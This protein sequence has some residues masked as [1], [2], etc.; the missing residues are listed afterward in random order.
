M[1]LSEINK[2]KNIRRPYNHVA[3]IDIANAS[4]TDRAEI[5][6]GVQDIFIYAFIV[7]AYSEDGYRLDKITAGCDLFKMSVYDD[8]GNHLQTNPVVYSS[9]NK[10]NTIPS[11]RGYYFTARS[12]VTIEME[13]IGF[14]GAAAITYPAKFKV[15]LFGYRLDNYDLI[16]QAGEAYSRIIRPYTFTREF[17]LATNTSTDSDTID[18]GSEDLFVH[19]IQTFGLDSSGRVLEEINTFQDII[20][21]KM[22]HGAE[23]F[24][25]NWID[26]LA[27]NEAMKSLHW[28][29]WILE[30]NR[31]L[32][33][34]TKAEDFPGTAV[35]NFPKKWQLNL[36][37]YKLK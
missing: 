37:G 9:L 7:T 27:I 28:K 29:G 2:L 12:K 31:T 14:P 33:I 18:T 26:I 36:T 34:E 22:W 4:D 10:M 17:D 21:F 1:D 13:A 35:G 11:F 6:I 24:Q 23:H 32:E 20:S 16:N 8:N 5:R 3:D 19:S 25:D 15:H 30:K